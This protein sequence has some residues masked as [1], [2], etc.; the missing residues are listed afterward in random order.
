MIRRSAARIARWK[1]AASQGLAG[2]QNLYAQCLENGIGVVRDQDEAVVWY[3][4]AAEQGYADAEYKLGLMYEEGRGV[5]RNQQ[6][7]YKLIRQA[8]HQDHVFASF[9]FIHVYKED[10]RAEDGERCLRRAA[11][12][13][14]PEA[15]FG[16]GI[17]Y[18]NAVHGKDVAEALDWLRK[19][20]DQGYADAQNK[21]A[22]MYEFGDD[23]GKDR[24]VAMHWYQEAAKQGHE[25]AIT[26]LKRLKAPT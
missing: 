16:M 23:V 19:A 8:A 18:L 10:C 17:R 2:A 9:Y 15:Q 20:A 26:A 12:K 24:G 14:H 11:E 21:L 25:T 3:R 4:K 22:F 1:E 5:K 7:A 6:L 13:G